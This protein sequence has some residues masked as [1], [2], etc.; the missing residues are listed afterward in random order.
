MLPGD[1][2]FCR[3]KGVC[4]A[5]LIFSCQQIF[6]SAACAVLTSCL[7]EASA[8]VP[9]DRPRYAVGSRGWLTF[10]GA[11]AWRLK[12]YIDRS[13]MD[14]YGA[15]LPFQDGGSMSAMGG[16]NGRPGSWWSWLTG[17]SGQQQL[18]GAYQA[19]GGEELELL[20]AASAMRCGGCGAK[21]GSSTLRRALARVRQWKEQ[22]EHQLGGAQCQQHK[23]RQGTCPES[24]AADHILAHHGQLGLGADDAAVLPPPPPGQLAVSTIDFFRSFWPDAYLLGAIA[25]NHA[26]GVRSAGVAV[27]NQSAGLGT[28]VGLMWSGITVMS[29][30]FFDPQ[31][32][33]HLHQ[34]TTSTIKDESAL[35]ILSCVAVCYAVCCHPAVGMEV[36]DNSPCMHC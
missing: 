9:G 6:L 13:F 27:V 30:W 36:P 16:S 7:A 25:A 8:C 28:A 19:A 33:W 29:I 14:K 4:I 22:Q 31:D 20:A 26:L 12:D 10:Q 1:I 21:V 34:P 15:A 2:P 18:P 17:A 3:Y 32:E 5:F 11:W 23:H 35:T 24:P